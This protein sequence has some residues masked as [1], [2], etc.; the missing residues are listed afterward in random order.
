MFIFTWYTENLK[1]RQ[2]LNACCWTQTI[3]SEKQF[4]QLKYKKVIIIVELINEIQLWLRQ[5]NYTNYVF[6]ENNIVFVS[7]LHQLTTYFS[8]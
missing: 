6:C 5:K 4:L 7:H 1:I 2:A 8:P 3:R